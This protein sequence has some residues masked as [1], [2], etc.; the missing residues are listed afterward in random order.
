VV[1]AY[2]EE[3]AARLGDDHAYVVSET[4]RTSHVAA[5]LGDLR[6]D[7][8]ST[9][10][11]ERYAA[12]RRLEPCR[13]GRPVAR[14]S[15]REE[16]AAWQRAV[17]C[18]H[19]LGRIDYAPCKAPR[20][21]SIPSDARPERR[22][23]EAEVAA[24]LRAAEHEGVWS[25]MAT[26]AWSGRRPIAVFAAHVEDCARVLDDDL[27]REHR[28]MWW[29]E[30]KGGV[31]RGWGPVTD[32]AYAALR[33]EAAERLPGRLWLTGYGNE[34]TAVRLSRVFDR[35]AERAGVEEVQPYDLRRFACTTI[36]GAVGGRLAVAQQYTG[37]RTVQSLLRYVYAPQ[38]E[39][40]RA[41]A[42]IGWSAPRLGLVEPADEG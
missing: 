6:A 21:K 42:G 36:V 2:V 10:H 12:R 37:H 41:A 23:T 26:L 28:L 38:G 39:A 27:A 25:L 40:E 5:L 32:P 8:V 24:L 30:D 15:L 11:L 31:G 13:T 29:R 4:Q 7:R 33:G 9:Q 3:I 18:L 16:I 19:D 22:L 14:K 35:I 34:W 20:L 17:R 1:I